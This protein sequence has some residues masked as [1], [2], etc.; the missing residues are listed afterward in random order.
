M[1]PATA[2]FS[3]ACRGWSR[4]RCSCVDA[5]ERAARVVRYWTLAQL[6]ADGDARTRSTSSSSRAELDEAVRI[7]LRSDVPLGAFLSG[8]IDSATVLALMAQHS[9][10]PVKTFSIGFGDPEYDELDGA[11]ATAA[12]VR[13]RPS[14]VAGRRPTA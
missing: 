6:R 1:W 13:R 10:R 3:R 12:H 14:R 7:R 8:G 4:A 2:R 9:P 5:A 11:R